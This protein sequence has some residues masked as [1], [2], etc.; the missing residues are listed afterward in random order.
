MEESAGAIALIVLSGLAIVVS[1]AVIIKGRLQR[2]EEESPA[3][4]PTDRA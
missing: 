3:N 4:P 2:D 1:L